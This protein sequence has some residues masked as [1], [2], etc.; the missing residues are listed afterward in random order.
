ML[1][2]TNPNPA[3]ASGAPVTYSDQTYTNPLL[4]NDKPVSS[5]ALYS[6]TEKPAGI[7]NEIT[8]N[9]TTGQVSF[10]KALYDAM[11]P[12]ISSFVSSSIPLVQLPARLPGPQTVTV[13]AA[14]QGKTASYTFTVTDHFSPREGYSSVVAGDDI[15]VMG[16]VIRR[17]VAPAVGVRGVRA[18]QSNEV[19]RSS[20]GG[21][22]WDQVAKDGSRFTSRGFHSSVVLG[23]GSAAE[24]YVIG[25]V[26]GIETNN[27]RDDVWKSTDR[28]VSW[29]KVTPAGGSVQFPMDDSFTSA[30]L[31]NALYVMGGRDRSTRP[32]TPR[33]QVWRSTTTA[34]TDLGV[35]WTNRTPTTTA[36]SPFPVRSGHTSVVLGSGSAAELYVIGGIGASPTDKNDVWKSSDGTNW[37]EVNASAAPAKKFTGRSSHSSAV[38]GNDI[39]VIGG[40]RSGVTRNDIWKSGDN[41]AAWDQVT[42]NPS[43]SLFPARRDHASVVQGGAIYVIGGSGG[44]GIILTLFNDVWK[45][46]DGGVNWVNLHKN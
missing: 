34:T 1:V 9:P 36:T 15:Y 17:L 16:G 44:S 28:G 23:S 29:I 11:K 33:N 20:D 8:V 18:V 14:Y 42:V 26:S 2:I 10:G 21:I 25:G 13:Q 38:V 43:S 45:S 27:P 30:V 37:T 31:G 19:W 41:G 12:S 3:A 39:Y 6:I 5:G 4:Y 22:T 40:V 35:T 7:T 24:L 32:L 46:T